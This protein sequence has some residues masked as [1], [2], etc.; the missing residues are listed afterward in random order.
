MPGS[1]VISGGPARQF[2]TMQNCR[3]ASSR[4]PFELS[5]IESFVPVDL[6]SPTP[7]DSFRECFIFDANM[8]D[9]YRLIFAWDKPQ[10]TLGKIRVK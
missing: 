1:S 6:F 5:V 2:D 8:P 9:A 10:G 7:A 3:P 4:N